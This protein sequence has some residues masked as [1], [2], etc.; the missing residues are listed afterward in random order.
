[1]NLVRLSAIFG[2][3]GMISAA[4]VLSGHA[5]SAVVSDL[6]GF[7]AVEP[8]KNV[9]LGDLHAN[10]LHTKAMVMNVATRK[11]REVAAFCT[12]PRTITQFWSWLSPRV[13][14]V[15]Q[16][17]LPPT[18]NESDSTSWWMD[19]YAIELTSGR[20]TDL[21]V[22]NSQFHQDGRPAHL[23]NG[24]GVYRAG[25][26]IGYIFDQFGPSQGLKS[27]MVKVTPGKRQMTEFPVG[28]SSG[29][30]CTV[31]PEG[32]L[33]ICQLPDD[34]VHPKTR[35][36]VYD[37]TTGKPINGATYH[38]ALSM[39]APDGSKLI[40]FR[41]RDSFCSDTSEVIFVPDV[42]NHPTTECR[43]VEHDAASGSRPWI[44]VT[45]PWTFSIPLD[46]YFNDDTEKAEWSADSNWFYTSIFDA[47][48]KRNK[49][50]GF[51]LNSACENGDLNPASA[52]ISDPKLNAR[53]PSVS[54]DG[55]S[56]VFIAVDSDSSGDQVCQTPDSMD[57]VAAYPVQTS[58]SRVQLYV[59]GS[60]AVSETPEASPGSQILTRAMCQHGQ[61]GE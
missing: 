36:Q 20:W 38:P 1:M 60:A 50:V 55:R 35:Q 7:T 6:I 9:I 61:N 15:Q 54:P 28:L 51:R 40:Y 23:F 48:T 25:A 47:V 39:W 45:K 13:V 10:T 16:M 31:S 3:W 8:P 5:Q 58:V 26:D 2:L 17:F 32:S 11:S 42:R 53:Y 22:T 29:H 56:V 43:L 4:V 21:T 24:F 14:I 44:H 12:G 41:C 46:K 34:S 37:L 33:A 19:E 52:Q 57:P 59:A 49:I 27:W 18:N 30:G